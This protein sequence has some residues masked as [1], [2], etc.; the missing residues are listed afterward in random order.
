MNQ[1]LE[2][3][4][5]RNGLASASRLFTI[6]MKNVYSTLRPKGICL[7][8]YIDNILILADSP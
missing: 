1:L 5:L 8:G 7:F 2:Y 3:V 6:L 4:A